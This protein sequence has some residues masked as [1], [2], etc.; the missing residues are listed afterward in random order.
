MLPLSTIFFS[1]KAC[2]SLKIN[3]KTVNAAMFESGAASRLL[4]LVL[5]I[6]NYYSKYSLT[7]KVFPNWDEILMINSKRSGI[8]FA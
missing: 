5:V 7:M 3:L 6:L 8:F 4:L 2:L 1:G